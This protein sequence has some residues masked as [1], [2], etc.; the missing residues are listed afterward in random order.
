MLA[1]LV[2]ASLMALAYGV[3]ISLETFGV[4]LTNREFGLLFMVAGLIYLYR[5]DCRGRGDLD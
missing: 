5:R 2:F 1:V 4:V 3:R